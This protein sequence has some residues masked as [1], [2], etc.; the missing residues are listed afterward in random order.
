MG[1]GHRPAF[2]R[3]LAMTG[4]AVLVGTAT[5]AAGPIAFAGLIVPYFARRLVGPDVRRALPMAMLIGPIVLL[6]SDILSRLTVR[7][8]ELPIGVVTACIG[9]PVL[10]AVV[11]SHR[12]PRL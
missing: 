12:L 9:A 7:P 1:L 8:Y 6:V 5:A 11:R 2:T 10:I 4:V 3:I